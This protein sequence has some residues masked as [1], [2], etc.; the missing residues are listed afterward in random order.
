MDLQ[1]TVNTRLL[2][3]RDQQYVIS[4]FAGVAPD[5]CSLLLASN[6]TEDALQYLEMGR[7]VILSQLIDGR[8]DISNLTR[9]HS[10]IALKFESFGEKST[11]LSAASSTAV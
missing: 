6:Q 9:Q 1:P 7:A 3:R 8:S 2:D 10:E 11:L 5:I 4:T